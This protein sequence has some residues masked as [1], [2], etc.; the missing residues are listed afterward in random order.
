MA[1]RA[2]S[3]TRRVKENQLKMA[4]FAAFLML[5]ICLYKN[6]KHKGNSKISIKKT[7]INPVFCFT[8]D[9]IG[10]CTYLLDAGGA[11]LDLL[12]A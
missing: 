5:H 3:L 10:F 11:Y 7:G 12:C 2:R 4:A 6:I 9:Y 8:N 1:R